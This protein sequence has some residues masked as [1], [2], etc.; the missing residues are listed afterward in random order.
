MKNLKL[1]YSLLVVLGAG[2]FASCTNDNAY[3]PGEVP[4]GPQVYWDQTNST[5]VEFAGAVE[6]ANQTLTLS[7]VV[8]DEELTIAIIAD[9]AEGA[10]FFDIPETVTFEQ[11]KATTKLEYVVDFEKFENDKQYSIIFKVMDSV[12]TP[13]GCSDW[14][15][16]YALNP[17]ELVKGGKG[18]FR[19]AD[20]IT[21]FFGADAAAEIEV[22]IYEHKN[23]SGLY[24]VEDPWL[25]TFVAAFGYSSKDEALAD[26]IVYTKTDLIINCENRNKCYISAQGIGID[27]GYGEIS[28]WSDYDP[29][30]YPDGIAGVLEDGVLTWAANGIYVSMANY[31]SG[32]WYPANSGGMFRLIWPGVELADYSLA[33]AYDGMDVSAD[34][35]TIS[36][37]LKFSYGG[38]VTGIKYVV[39]PGNIEDDHADVLSALANG[40]AENIL[41]VAD[42]AKGAG[43]ANVKVGLEKQG[44]YTVV[45]APADKNGALSA[46]DAVAV[47]FFFQG[48]GETVDTTCKLAGEMFLPSEINPEYTT[49]FPD[50]TSLFAVLVG[51]EIKSVSYYINKSAVVATWTDTL[52][53][54]V[55]AYGKALQT[56][57]LEYINSEDGGVIPFSGLAENTE[58]TA[59]FVATNVYGESKTIVLT[60]KTAK[61]EYTGELVIGDYSMYCK[62]VYGEGAEDFIESDN[63]FNVASNGGSTTDYLVTSIGIENG[64]VW[65]AKYDS[66]AGTLTL[67]GTELGYEEDYGNQFGGL[68]GYYDSA[69]TMAYGLFSYASAESYGDDTL[70]LAVDAT[71]KQ[72]SGLTTPL[73]SVEIYQMAEGYPFLGYYSY[74][75]SELTT[76]APY[77]AASTASV[78][79]VKKQSVVPFR[80]AKGVR[81]FSAP[82][83]KFGVN[84]KAGAVLNTSSKSVKTVKPTFVENYTPEKKSVGFKNLKETN[85]VA[86]RR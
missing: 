13:Y 22:D 30:Q 74:F 72:V 34:S 11:G 53:A 6:E 62:Y 76:I 57:N 55:A 69:K 16:T 73:F 38:D 36:A 20:V 23:I 64:A 8:T 44:H 7:R 33:A 15:V 9:I 3:A 68:Y 83:S 58:F 12:A 24:K 75:V 10:E 2:F 71:T 35:K 59:I 86:F 85:A 79:S 37:K 26:D 25:S 56:E 70:V 77:T 41:E 48:L 28:I 51:Q 42:F 65:H 60:K 32:K 43:V 1:L 39:V 47:S 4:A 49:L 45:A 54:L 29:E 27:V 52:E 46:K 66:A 80:N 31:Q 82:K 67:D 50:Q 61:Y 21:T 14:T 81:S 84:I 19:G 78:K 18:L 17:W 5:S 63:V 40:T